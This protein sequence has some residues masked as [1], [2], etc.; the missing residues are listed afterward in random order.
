MFTDRSD[1]GEH[2][3]Q[4]VTALNVASPVVL[5][6]PRGGLPVGRAV[7]RALGADLDVLIVRKIGA[8]HNPEFAIGA[9][10]EGGVVVLDASSIEQ[11]HIDPVLRDRLITEATAEI[12]RRVDSYRGGRSIQDLSGRTAVI[13]D[14]GLATGATAEAAVNVVRALGSARIVL[15]VPTGARSAVERLSA[16]CDDVVCLEQPEWFVSV[17]S[18]Y[19]DFPQVSDAEVVAILHE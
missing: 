18:Q 11:L 9:V 3:A 17:G 6:L 16:V 4:A 10:G 1:A 14:D 19:A 13:V 7:A 8:P 5:A 15:A 2:L 12:D